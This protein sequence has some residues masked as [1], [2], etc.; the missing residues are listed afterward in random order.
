MTATASPSGDGSNAATS[1]VETFLVT[2]TVP[3]TGGQGESGP[4]AGLVAGVV[5]GVVLAVVV[6]VVAAAIVLAVCSTWQRR[7]RCGQACDVPAVALSVA[8][9]SGMALICNPAYDNQK[10]S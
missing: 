8:D 5:V 4:N 10:N 1:T 3:A 7:N 9:D 6:V 2:S